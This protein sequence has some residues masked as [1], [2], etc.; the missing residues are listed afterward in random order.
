MAMIDMQKTQLLA[1]FKSGV[2][3]ASYFFKKNNNTHMDMWKQQ[4]I[5]S[6]IKSG[7]S[8]ESTTVSVTKEERGYL[9]VKILSP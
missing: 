8:L 4:E 1:I 6:P 7:H 9:C 3:L 2:L 5:I